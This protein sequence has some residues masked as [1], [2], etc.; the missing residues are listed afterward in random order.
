MR[1]ARCANRERHLDAVGGPSYRRSSRCAMRDAQRVDSMGR[2]RRSA[3]AGFPRCATRECQLNAIGRFVASR[4]AHRAS[5]IAALSHRALRH[6]RQ[7]R[8][9]A[10]QTREND[11]ST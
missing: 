2:G 5:R 11:H 10:P 3:A 7:T 9:K 1:D 4:I 8:T 6:S